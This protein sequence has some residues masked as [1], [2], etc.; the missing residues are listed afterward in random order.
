M[1]PHG[2]EIF[3]RANHHKVVPNVAHH[4]QL[5]FFPTQRGFLDQCLMH[6]TGIQRPRDQVTKLLPI[7]SNRT[8]RSAQRERRPNHHGISK[9]V[10]QPHSVGNRSHHFRRRHLQPNFAANI[11]EQQP[12][13][14]NFDRFQRCANQLHIIFFENP[15]FRQLHRKIQPCLSSHRRQQ[16][17]RPLR[18]NNRLQIFLS[19]RLNVSPVRSLR[20]RHNR[21]RIRIDQH[22]LVPFRAQ[23]LA[24][25]RPRVVKLAPLPN[26]NR[27]R[28]DDQYFLNVSPFRH[29]S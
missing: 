3:N 7:V 14:R 27:P 9:L 23:R 28:A 11:L 13:F 4:F 12:I 18:R 5:V 8:P 16:R 25:L 17:V 15:R 10:R 1:N 26:H 20:V 22:H 24:S 29:G 6:R 2:V 21:R 19:Q